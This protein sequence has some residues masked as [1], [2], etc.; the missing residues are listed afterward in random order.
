ME[1]SDSVSSQ[2]E[3]PSI[4]SSSLEFGSGG[5]MSV[6]WTDNVTET[7]TAVP[8]P[9]P[10]PAP[11]EIIKPTK[12]QEDA[13]LTSEELMAIWGRIGVQVCEVATSL[14]DKSKRALIGDG[15]YHGFIEAVLHEVPG[16]APPAPPS[17]GYIIYMQSGFFEIMPGDVVWL[18][19]AKLKGHKGIQ[20]YSQH[21][22]V[23]EPLV[24]IISEFEAKKFKLR[25]FQANQHVGQQTVESSGV[26]KVGK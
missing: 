17:Y 20:T 12:S 3:L 2:W 10:A 26:V 19:D 16:A 13:V 23:K 15:T 8:A 25:V 5:T 22:G 21:V 9:A 24:G 1:L 11:P 14:H 4:P 6:S 7:T 18:S